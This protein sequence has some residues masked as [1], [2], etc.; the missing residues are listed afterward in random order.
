MKRINRY[1]WLGL[2]CTLVLCS[3]RAQ[4]QNIRVFFYA[5]NAAMTTN[6]TG[7]TAAYI[8]ADSCGPNSTGYS[9]VLLDNQTAPIFRAMAPPAIRGTYDSLTNNGSTMRRRIMQIRDLSNGV[10]NDI[11]IYLFDDTS[12]L[13]ATD[14]CKCDEIIGGQRVVWPCASNFRRSNGQYLGYVYLGEVAANDIINNYPGGYWAWNETVLHEFSH[15]QFAAEYNAAGERIANKWGQNGISI[16]Y[17][18]DQGHWGSEIQGD[19][20][21][22]LDEGLATFWGMERNRVGRDSLVNWLNRKSE[23]FYLGSH[24]VLTGWPEMWNAPH[25]VVFSGTIPANRQVNPPG[26]NT[27]RLVSPDIETGAGYELRGY[28]WLDVPGKYA[29]YNEQMFQ[30]FA[31]LFFEQAMPN[32]NN[33][34]DMMLRSAKK[35]TAPNNRLRYPALLANA[36][37]NELEAH[38]ATPAGRTSETNG[39]LVSSMFVYALYDI[40]THFGMSEADLRRELS[41]NMATYV[42]VP[43]P[44]AFDEYWNHR[45]AVKALVCPFLGGNDCA[46]GNGNIDIVRAA[47]EAKT[48]FSDPSRILR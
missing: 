28:K 6:F 14:T 21:S 41:T 36:L 17:G 44:K 37:A 31:M 3:F 23:R 33:A 16:S 13:A 5:P 11:E 29:F 18:G 19:Q 34:F 40:I 38:A 1:H 4:A 24:S 12:G 9:Y 35:M 25:T 8:Q 22:P 10:V 27:I 39:T 26:W 43:K 7:A 48:Y 42:P 47:Q 20:Q 45:A 30:G 46:P 2:I 32:R 15:T